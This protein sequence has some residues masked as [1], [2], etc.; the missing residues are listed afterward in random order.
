MAKKPEQR[1]RPTD[2]TESRKGDHVNIVLGKNVQYKKSA[3][4]EEVDFLHCALPEC[5]FGKID[6]SC[7]FLGKKLD[8]PLII[9]A[10]T[11]GYGAAGKINSAL[12][13]AAERHKLAFGVGSQRAMFENKGL[14]K[15]YYV[16][17]VAPTVPI[18]ANI[19]GVQLRKYGAEAIA[20]LVSAI[21][22]DALAVHLNA[23]QEIVQPEGDHD[24]TGVL[25]A[26]RK[27]CEKLDVPVVVKETGAGISGDIAIKL[28][29]VGVRYIDVSGTGGTSWS[30]VEYARNGTARGFEE[31]GIPTVASILMCKGILPLI[32]SGGV[33]SGIDAAK[34]ISLGC[35]IAGAAHPFLKSMD[36]SAARVD[37]TISEWAMQMRICAF[38]TGSK[39]YQELKT[40]KIVFRN[41]ESA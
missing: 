25:A 27:A 39:N 32:G 21:E 1:T 38:L 29:D 9:T 24:F 22:A 41:T 3:G 4:F 35:D 36:S 34:C 8:M 6:L 11:G 33:R 16:R 7:R 26:I 20:G 5:D 31:W 40:A 12:A 15:T 19:G 14:M 10:M 37:A 28:R 13:T 18:L 23:L 17:D 30:K 2:Q